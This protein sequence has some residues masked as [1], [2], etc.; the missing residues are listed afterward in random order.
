MDF[1]ERFRLGR[2]WPWVLLA[3]LAFFA[4]VQFMKVNMP[5][6]ADVAA[7]GFVGEAQQPVEV[8][9]RYALQLHGQAQ[10]AAHLRHRVRGRVCG[11]L[12]STRLVA[13]EFGVSDCWSGLAWPRTIATSASRVPK[14][15]RL[16][17]WR[18]LP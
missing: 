9:V 12:D 17:A 2:I 18:G 10:Q 4:A 1:Y 5:D 14:L 13:D 15:A 16:L 3:V 7:A 11:S 6:I 8:L